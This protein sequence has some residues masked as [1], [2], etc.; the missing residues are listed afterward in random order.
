MKWLLVGLLF[1]LCS[2]A[3]EGERVEVASVSG[4]EVEL[5]FE[6]DG[7]FFVSWSDPRPQWL[8]VVDD[9]ER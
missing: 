6:K 7:R 5:L 9:Q 8:H 1:A 2:C 3:V 4:I